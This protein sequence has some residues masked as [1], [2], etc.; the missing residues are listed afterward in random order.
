MKKYKIKFKALSFGGNMINK[1]L[2]IEMPEFQE[3]NETII[4]NGNKFNYCLGIERQVMDYLDNMDKIHIMYDNEWATIIDYKM[5]VP[6]ERV[7]KLDKITAFKNLVI[8]YFNPNFEH[9]DKLRDDVMV[10]YIKMYDKIKNLTPE[11]QFMIVLGTLN[12]GYA[13]QSEAY[14]HAIDLIKGNIPQSLKKLG[15]NQNKLS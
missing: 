10:V 4:V 13:A 2:Q 8:N 5:Y 7:T 14:K 3:K 11:Q 15:K 1:T 6:K 12:V 9:A